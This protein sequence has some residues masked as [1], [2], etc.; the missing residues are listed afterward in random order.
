MVDEDTCPRQIDEP[1]GSRYGLFSAHSERELAPVDP[2][3]DTLIPIRLMIVDNSLVFLG[4][5]RRLL[6]T[7][8]GIEVVGS[9]T[10]GRDALELV[11]RV[12][13]DAVLTDLAMPE[14]DGL[15]MARLLAVRSGKPIVVIMSIHNLTSYRQAARAAGADAFITKSDLVNRIQPLLRHLQGQRE[16]KGPEPS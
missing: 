13:P 14:L 2:E 9:A 8:P 5:L 1:K 12:H 15:Q 11:D 4:T 10:S 3:A 6:E 16:S 7:T